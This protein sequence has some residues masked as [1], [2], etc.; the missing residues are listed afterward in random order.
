MQEFDLLVLG[1]INPDLILSGDDVTP[2]FA[3][4]EKLVE[5][6]TLTIGAS[7]V[8]TACATARLGLR[9]TFV[10]V[11]GDDVFGH[12]MLQA[13]NERGVDTSSCIVDP[14]VATGLSVILSKPHDRAI[15]THLGATAALRAGQVDEALFQRVRHVHVGSLFLLDGLRP[16]LPELFAK[17]RARGLTTSLDT[18]WDPSGGWNGNVAQVLPECD[19][20][21]PNEAEA[22]LISGC[23][24]LDAA[25]ERLADDV[26][27]LAVKLGPDGGLARQGDV[28]VRA[29][30]LSVEV[31][32]TTGAGDTFDAGFLYGCLKGWPLERSLQ[33]ACACGS[34]S[35]RS[36]GGVRGQ[37]TLSEALVAMESA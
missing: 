17:A 1:E 30:A 14:N 19:I 24:S 11:V 28:I 3:Q 12:F 7:S 37:P 18:N 9:T 32:D 35:T 5:T 6:V 26:P 36:A 16:D 2:A 33:L 34:L 8:I 31:I 29:P 27:T 21:M 15:L 4:V 23:D 20:F 10:G 22:R 25:L 13:M